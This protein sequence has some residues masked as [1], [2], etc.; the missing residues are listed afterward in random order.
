MDIC[1]I[2]TNRNP[3]TVLDIGFWY[4][5]PPLHVLATVLAPTDSGV[6]YGTNYII[7]AGNSFS[8]MEGEF[9]FECATRVLTPTE[10][11]YQ[12]GTSKPFY[13]IKN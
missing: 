3:T 5:G 8:L 7:F 9:D 2:F 6:D 10:A 13:Y 11:S 4:D 1:F 12:C